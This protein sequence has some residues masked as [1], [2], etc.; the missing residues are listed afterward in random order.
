MTLLVS[1]LLIAAIA[2]AIAL[3]LYRG[4]R[5]SVTE[6][7]TA[8]G[9][10]ERRKR[11]A[12]LA[13]RET[14]FDRA[15]GKLSEEDY[16]SLTATYESRALE[17]MEAMENSPQAATGPPAGRGPVAYCDHCGQAFGSTDRFC[18]GCGGQR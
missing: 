1:V 14:E 16:H 11:V 13:I 10:L 15:M 2:T 5:D 9:D 8:A 18:A 17:A 3:P 12:M 7:L 4:A 6:G